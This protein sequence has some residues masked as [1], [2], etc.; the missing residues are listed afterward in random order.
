MSFLKALREAE[1]ARYDNY[2]VNYTMNR[3]HSIEESCT[4]GKPLPF[5]VS[6]VP[7]IEIS[8]GSY[9]MDSD[10]F[11][12][13]ITTN[14]IDVST[15]ITNVCKECELKPN[16]LSIT[17]QTESADKLYDLITEDAGKMNARCEAVEKHVS[18]M[19]QIKE[20][21]VGIILY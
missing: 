10:L 7:V 9:A 17:I 8:E 12:K 20:S 3:L 18:Y 5:T 13:Y 11:S 14:S 4:L 15:G 21:D 16:Q 1:S 19:E 6:M 2:D